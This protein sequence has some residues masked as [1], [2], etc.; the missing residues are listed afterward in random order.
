MSKVDK[1]HDQIIVGLSQNNGVVRLDMECC[2][3]LAQDVPVSVIFS[4][5]R[6]VVVD[7]IPNAEIK[8]VSDEG[9]AVHFDVT[10]QTVTLIIEWDSFETRDR[11]MKFYNFTF[12][13]M[14]I[15]DSA[16]LL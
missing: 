14:E 11:L 9:Q 15:S 12:D 4:G 1:F 16:K 13:R 8:M 2:A 10:G 3:G 7:H 5:V 6:N